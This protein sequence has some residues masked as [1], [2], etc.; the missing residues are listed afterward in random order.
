MGA[1]PVL[2]PPWRG[3]SSSCLREL[4]HTPAL[5][6]SR[7]PGAGSRDGSWDGQTRHPLPWQP[8]SS[9]GDKEK[10][11]PRIV[12]TLGWAHPG[13]GKRSPM[14]RLPWNHIPRNHIPR[15]HISAPQAAAAR[16][17]APA[18]T[19][20][21][22]AAPNPAPNPL[23][24]ALGQHGTAA[25]G[26][27]HLVLSSLGFIQIP[28]IPGEESGIKPGWERCRCS[29]GA[30]SGAGHP[31]WHRATTAWVALSG[32]AINER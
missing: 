5:L 30:G 20:T 29:P 3:G 10:P 1:C 7:S 12:P 26:V 15:N 9:G 18:G 2:I 6:S 25:A 14:A 13:L 21:R 27:W 4:W 22:G 31:R 16:T 32:A 23:P 11:R 24:K 19:P 8:R 28:L 17:P